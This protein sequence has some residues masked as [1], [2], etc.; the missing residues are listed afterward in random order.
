MLGLAPIA[1]VIA[2]KGDITTLVYI[3]SSWGY[4]PGL[5]GFRLIVLSSR[6]GV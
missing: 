2:V 1:G 4:V 5:P 6:Y 3:S